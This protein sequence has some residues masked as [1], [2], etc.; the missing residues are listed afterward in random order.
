ME[1][2]DDQV[3][4]D[5]A[6][7]EHQRALDAGQSEP[8]GH[9]DRHIETQLLKTEPATLPQDATQASQAAAEPVADDRSAVADEAG[10]RPSPAELVERQ[11]VAE[12]HPFFE[13]STPQPF[14]APA[15]P[16]YAKPYVREPVPMPTAAVVDEYR[17]G[18]GVPEQTSLDLPSARPAEAAS[19]ETT[20]WE[21]TIADTGA[22]TARLPEQQTDEPDLDP[23]QRQIVTV[24][25]WLVEAEKAGEKLSGAEAARRLGL[26]PKTG[27]RRVNAAVE[28]LEEQ[29]RQQGRAH[30]RSVRS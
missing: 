9:E 5:P 20:V 15:V 10:L 29:R 17:A 11:A 14:A 1:R 12:Q 23:V 8:A 3:A 27:Q 18:G 16:I 4:A 30:L 22:A 28:H 19:C 25:E 6:T 7:G 2:A 26:S 24:A 13:P 21:S